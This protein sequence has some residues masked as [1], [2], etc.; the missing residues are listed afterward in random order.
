MRDVREGLERMG[1]E[2]S[3][4]GAD[5]VMRDARASLRRR[6]RH[7]RTGPGRDRRP[8]SAL[9]AV[10]VVVVA[11][12]AAGALV[13]L[14]DRDR[15]DE[16]TR[17]A[18]PSVV[19]GD[20]DAVVLSSN[21]DADLARAQIDP[22]VLDAVRGIDGVTGAQGAI[23]RF[24]EVGDP[25]GGRRVEA[26]EASERSTIAVQ[27]EGTTFEM[28]DGRMPEGRGEIAINS[29]LSTRFQTGPGGDLAVSAGPRL[30]PMSATCAEQLLDGRDPDGSVW[31][32]V[33]CRPSSGPV[34]PPPKHVVGVFT[35][36]GGDV[37]DV[38]L[39]AMP[40]DELQSLTS[41]TGFDRIDVTVRDGEPLEA[42]LDR[43]GAALPAGLIVVPTSVVNADDQLRSELDIQRAYFWLLNTDPEKRA[44][45]SEGRPD[46]QGPAQ[47]EATYQERRSEAVDAE[48]RVSRVAFVDLD[49]AIVS[50]RVYY[51][52]APSPIADVPLTALVVRRDGRWLVSS[53]G[54]CQL[55]AYADR[56]CDAP[57]GPDDYVLAPDGWASPS[58]HADSVA[59]LRVLADPASTVDARVVAVE[60][61]DAVRTEVQSGAIADAARGGGVSLNVLGARVLAPGRV[62]VLYS[63]VADGEPRIETPY[64]VTAT[65]VQV[66]GTWKLVRRYACGLTALAGQP[67]ALPGAAAATTTTTTTTTPPTTTTS[68]AALP[69]T[70]P[71]PST[72]PTTTTSP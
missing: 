33:T 8:A 49:T 60:D 12:V 44:Q 34:E 21:L 15:S 51:N 72:T 55:A 61:G 64:P 19:V 63:L 47:S 67:C 53:Q 16:P 41:G 39:L 32:S 37:A 35:L 30:S 58:D 38:N 59:A 48:L 7:G 24:V 66:D 45:A 5:A 46:D 43:I 40:G 68:S 69:T 71:A 17:V 57:D 9:V 26:D 50:Y 13:T 62:Q 22:A 20:A 27:A 42:V 18:A 31:K 25:D 6:P 65:V 23:R 52:G 2:G 1:D 29:V 36:P 4:R 56:P 28:I 3:P 14:I 70:E 10:V 11:V 54:I